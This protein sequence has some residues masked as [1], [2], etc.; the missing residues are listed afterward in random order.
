MMGGS[1][2]SLLLAFKTFVFVLLVSVRVTQK[3]PVS[4]VGIINALRLDDS[5]RVHHLSLN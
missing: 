2:T 4:W 5:T 1:Q 3:L